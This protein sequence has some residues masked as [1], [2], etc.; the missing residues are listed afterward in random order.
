VAAMLLK[1]KTVFQISLRKETSTASSSI[2]V[3]TVDL[4]EATY[5]REVSAKTYWLDLAMHIWKTVRFIVSLMMYIVVISPVQIKW[6]S[7]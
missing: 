4:M 5:L 3:H 6:N 7:I 1:F 2:L